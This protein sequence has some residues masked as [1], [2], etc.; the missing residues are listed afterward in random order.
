P[1]RVYPLVDDYKAF[2]K[3]FEEK[4]VE[5]YIINTGKFMGKDIPPKVT[6]ESIEHNVENDADFKAFGPVEAFEYLPIEGYEVTFEDD[7]YREK[8]IKNMG[9][10]I[11]HV[12]TT[13]AEEEAPHDL[14][15]EIAQSIQN[16]VDKLN[17]KYIKYYNLSFKAHCKSL[18]RRDFL[19]IMGLISVFVK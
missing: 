2:K 1:F 14:P 4:D 8:V 17:N 9:T 19:I 5:C 7:E 12:K 3:L 11:D 15:D 16:I 6:L 18:F 10:R 13:L